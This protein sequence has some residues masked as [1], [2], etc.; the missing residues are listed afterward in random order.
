[1][2]QHTP[3]IKD[4][5]RKSG[6]SSATVSYVLNNGPR[7]VRP[8][9]RERV[10]RA[11]RD[12]GYRPS[13]IARGPKSRIMG[14]LGVVFPHNSYS[15]ITNPYFISILDGIMSTAENRD[16]NTIILTRR[17]FAN[18]R[19]SI[20]VHCDGHCDGLLL[21][22]PPVDCPIVAA[23]QERAIPFVLISDVS[24]DPTVTCVDVD[25]VEAFEQV[26]TYVIRQGHRK[27]ALLHGDSQLGSVA[28]RILGYRR[29]LEAAAI[30][31]EDTLI[32][33]GK[34]EEESGYERACIAMDLPSAQRPT[35]LLCG[36]DLVALGA[37][38][39]LRER[40]IRV[41]EDVSLV[42]FDD[43]PDAATCVPPLTTVRQPL[44]R[45]G[46][47]AV[48]R[49]FAQIHDGIPPGEKELLPTELVIR[50]SVAPPRSGR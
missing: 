15:L 10:L 37:L 2:R 1:L 14:T 48:E 27:M 32:L 40:N 35:A 9:T 12:L 38:R 34:Y 21:I 46:E 17:V 8:E 31:Y 26:S 19:Q 16:Q 20:R 4:V 44:Q 36:N 49:L 7:A 50:E 43:I 23:L 42:G 18:A 13:P 39:A 3:T 29:A 45:I 11:I 33:P 41:P 25:N 24:D 28:P 47:R 30:A 22:A 6:V 5:G